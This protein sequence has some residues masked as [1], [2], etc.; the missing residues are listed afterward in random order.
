VRAQAKLHAAASQRFAVQDFAKDVVEAV[1]NLQH[2]IASLPRPTD[3]EA[4]MITRLRD[5]FAG[6]YRSFIHMLAGHGITHS[7]PTGTVFDSNFHQAIE[8]Q[9]SADHVQGVVL[10]AL[11]STWMLNGRLLRP[12]MVIVSSG[13]S[14]SGSATPPFPSYGPGG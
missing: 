8:Q 3:R 4:E 6:I 5:G 1:D 2:A 10:H 13:S 12:A 9:V 7:D 14:A 11:T